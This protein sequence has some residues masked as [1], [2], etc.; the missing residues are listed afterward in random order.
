MRPEQ[1]RLALVVGMLLSA[2]LLFAYPVNP[3]MNT[4]VIFDDEAAIRM[5]EEGIQEENYQLVLRFTHDE[6]GQITSDLNRVQE[7]IQLE[8]EFL[9][10][11]NPQTSWDH[12]ELYIDRVVTPFS[13]WS[14]AFESRNRSLENATQWAD[15]LLP[16]IEDGWCGNQAT[17]EE[18]TAFEA[19]L[20]MLPEGT[21]FGIACPAFSGAS[22]TQPPATNEILWLVYV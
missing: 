20:L 15:V 1:L 14:D 22:A 11:T 2:G 19:S 3:K 9:D 21:N 4:E 6:G 18:Q 5:R 17:D 8:S 10:G 7:L 12:D 16:E 13:A